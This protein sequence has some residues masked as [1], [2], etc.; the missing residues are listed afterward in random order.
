[1]PQR[2][3]FSAMACSIARSWDV[4]GEPWTP[5]IIRDLFI[6]LHRFDQLKADLGI[7]P[8]I[9]TARLKT[10][11]A[12]GVVE[13]RPYSDGGRIRHE[14]YLT[15]MGD[16]LVPVIVALTNWGDTW[17]SEATPPAIIRHVG[18]GQTP[19]TAVVT[20]SSCGEALT[21]PDIEAL[22]GP[23]ADPGPGTQLIGGGLSRPTQPA[24]L[25][26]RSS[27]GSHGASARG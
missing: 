2:T 19:V 26:T 7:A 15:T 3:D 22:P 6:G 21:A 9:L 12:A 24:S 18:C 20:C 13:R 14:Y 8:N 27:D 10:L 4:I 23:G 1:M 5:L 16:E 25:E 17:L 11:T